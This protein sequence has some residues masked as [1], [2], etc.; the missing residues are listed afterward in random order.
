MIGG[1]VYP[2]VGA[3]GLA[4]CR[5]QLWATGQRPHY[6]VVYEGNDLESLVARAAAPHQIVDNPSVDREEH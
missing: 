6:D 4:E 5:L 2:L 1:A 3:T